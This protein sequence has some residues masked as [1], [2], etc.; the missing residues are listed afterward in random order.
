MRGTVV[1]AVVLLAGTD[2]VVLFAKLGCAFCT[3]GSELN[4]GVSSRRHV[5]LLGAT[6]VASIFDF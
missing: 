5:L 1:N 2:A 6:L 4:M 3:P